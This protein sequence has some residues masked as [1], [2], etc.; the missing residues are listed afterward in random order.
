[1]RDAATGEL[2]AT[3]AEPVLTVVERSDAEW[4]RQTGARR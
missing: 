2:I 3:L 1:V 4:A